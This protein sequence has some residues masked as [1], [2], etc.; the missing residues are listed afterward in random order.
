MSNKTESLDNRKLVTVAQRPTEQQAAI[1]VAVLA[2][3]DIRAV[4]TGGY[5][6]GFQAEA[7]GWVSVQTFEADAERA[8]QII[9]ELKA[10]D[11]GLNEK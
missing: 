6:A 5:T 2:D 7:P 4:A 11:E 8:K 9:A 1:L 3:E 10:E